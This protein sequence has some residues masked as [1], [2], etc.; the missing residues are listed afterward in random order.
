MPSGLRVLIVDDN[1]DIVL[2]TMALLR[3]DGHETRGCHN[4]SEVFGC[5]REYDPDVV[6]LDIGLPGMSG[7]E[8]ARQIRSGLPGKR[9][10]LIAITG[11][12]TKGSHKM[13]GEMSGFDS[14]LV[15]PVDPKVLLALI[16]K[17]RPKSH[18]E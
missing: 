5:V 11:E 2:T 14:Y 15:K 9:P 16:D 3:I 4:G 8:V 1:H 7:W 17:A 6:L 10:V 18:P 12:F 13:L